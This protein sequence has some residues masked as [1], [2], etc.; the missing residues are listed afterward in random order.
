MY[1]YLLYKPF[2]R[3]SYA[4]V[5][6]IPYDPSDFYSK[7]FFPVSVQNMNVDVKLSKRVDNTTALAPSTSGTSKSVEFGGDVKKNDGPN[8]GSG[9]KER[10]C[11]RKGKKPVADQALNLYR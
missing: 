5:R 1:S 11:K 10:N 6:A 3:E 9:W 2:N 8:K 4:Q 7:V